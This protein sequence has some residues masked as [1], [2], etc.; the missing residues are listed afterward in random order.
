MLTLGRLI[1]NV[2]MTIYVFV[3]LYFEE[4]TLAAELGEDYERYLKNTPS[5]IPHFYAKKQTDNEQIAR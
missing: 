2:L 4:R 5:V 1:F 3:G